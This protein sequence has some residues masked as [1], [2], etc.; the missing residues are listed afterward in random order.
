MCINQIWQITA[1][2]NNKA[3]AVNSQGEEVVASLRFFTEEL[4]VGDKVIIEGG[5]V[6]D[7][8]IINNKYENKNS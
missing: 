2:T 4:S 8:I 1:L 5:F 6:I 3:V 7:K